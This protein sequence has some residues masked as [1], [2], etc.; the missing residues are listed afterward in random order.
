[1]KL[2]PLTED[3]EVGQMGKCANGTDSTEDHL[4]LKWGTLKSWT[5]TSPKGQELIQKY[6][7]LGR[8]LSAMSQR[9]TPEQ[10]EL[11]CQ[12]I[13]ECGAPEIYLDWDGKDVSKE[14]AKKYVREYK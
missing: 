3:N 2:H 10:K 5:L 1:M 12:I 7:D 8:S 9:D 13:D 6:F 11:L 4:T 14:E